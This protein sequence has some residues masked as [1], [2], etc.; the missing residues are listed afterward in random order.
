ML[1][2]SRICHSKYRR[3]YFADYVTLV[4][5]LNLSEPWL[6]SEL[7]KETIYTCFLSMFFKVNSADASRH[8]FVNK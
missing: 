4:K 5:S 1:E 3:I 7:K 6:S 2:F 8:A